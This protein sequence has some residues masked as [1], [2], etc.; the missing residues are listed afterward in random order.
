MN[1][2]V[3]TIFSHLIFF[4]TL[5]GC[6]P[7]ALIHTKHEQGTTIEDAQ[8]ALENNSYEKAYEI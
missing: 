1:K 3:F 4:T 7:K 6:S 2:I 5:I 8:R